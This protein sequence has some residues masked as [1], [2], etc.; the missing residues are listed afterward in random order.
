MWCTFA[1]HLQKTWTGVR[2]RFGKSRGRLIGW[3][4]LAML[5]FPFSVTAEPRENG[6]VILMYH[7]LGE[8]GIP[9][10]NI[11]MAQFESH[12]EELTSGRYN[13]LPLRQVIDAIQNG[14]PLPERTVVITI[15]DAYRSVYT[16][17][18]PRL[19]EAGLPFT[20]FVSTGPL[21]QKLPG[22]M[23]WDQLRQLRD[24]GVGIGNHTA[25]HPHMPDLD[26]QRAKEE[27]RGSQHRFRE[28]LG[29][30]PDMFSYPYGETDF[31]RMDLVRK[32][33]FKAGF[34]QHSGVVYPGMQTQ[35]YLP[36]FPINE[37][38]G[39]MKRFQLVA[40][41]LPLPVKSFSPANPTLESGA[42]RFTMTL[43]DLP[44]NLKRLSCFAS[45]E[46]GPLPVKALGGG[47]FEIRLFRPFSPGRGRI[48][49]TVPGPDGRWHWFGMQ[50]YVPRKQGLK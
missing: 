44:V 34:G 29:R 31:Q 9:A 33:G 49:C 3:L 5:A 15:D 26:L 12:I 30:A 47:S 32:E 45:N 6:A 13:V 35:Y 46:H 38:Y 48:N 18:W 42:S 10:T 28:E 22:Y 43:G 27:L 16:R 23:T 37:T 19:K 50:Y 7:R 21:D 8:D 11:R 14:Q 2:V 39:S 41:A 1:K 17:A 4:M 25:S 24:A 20:V 36:R 40:N